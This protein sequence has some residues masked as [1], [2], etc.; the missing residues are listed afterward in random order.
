MEKEKWKKCIELWE[1]VVENIPEGVLA[2][3]TVTDLKHRWFKEMKIN[4]VDNS[5][6]FCA[7]SQS[8]RCL[9]CPGQLIDPT[10][11]CGNE[12]YDWCK[13]PKEFLAKLKELYIIAFSEENANG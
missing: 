5:C 9:Q 3:W 6:F 13:K 12:V 10:F 2:A 7:E 11:H 4:S 8:N 1:Y